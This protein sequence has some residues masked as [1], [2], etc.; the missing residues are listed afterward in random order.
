MYVCVCV[1]VCTYMYDIWHGYTC[2]YTYIHVPSM[3]LSLIISLN[4]SYSYPVNCPSIRSWAYILLNTT[5]WQ[6]PTFSHHSNNLW[7]KYE[8]LPWEIIYEN[9]FYCQS[10]G[11]SSHTLVIMIM[12]ESTNQIIYIRSINHLYMYI[13]H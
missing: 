12:I 5:T 1:S 4:S 7:E 8:L 10:F 2:T 6:N 13:L 9:S 11:I 3:L